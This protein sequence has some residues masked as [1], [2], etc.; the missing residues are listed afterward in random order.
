[1]ASESPLA[2]LDFK[3]LLFSNVKN[4]EDQISNDRFV[5]LLPSTVKVFGSELKVFLTSRDFR[6]KPLTIE[7]R[8]RKFTLFQD[9]A[10]VFV[11]A[12]LSGSELEET[13]F[14]PFYYSVLKHLTKVPYGDLLYLPLLIDN[15]TLIDP[16][17]YNE[18]P[19]LR[20][21][22]H[23]LKFYVVALVHY[24]HQHEDKSFIARRKI[25]FEDVI[26]NHQLIRLFLCGKEVDFQIV[27]KLQALDLK[28]ISILRRIFKTENEPTNETTQCSIQ[29][30]ITMKDKSVQTEFNVEN[31]ES[32]QDNVRDFVHLLKRKLDNKSPEKL[33]KRYKK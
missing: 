14:M 28:S 18:I 22:G 2:E 32:D 5:W 6:Y 10:Q 30:F 8:L 3:V 26:D 7:E 16:L 12:I 27:G 31:L 23:K 4:T 9:K 15:Y 21:D 17:N 19:W 20:K 1:M 33:E 13:G 25:Y 11:F 29:D 24:L